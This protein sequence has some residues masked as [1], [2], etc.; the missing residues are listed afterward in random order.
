[1]LAHRVQLVGQLLQILHDRL[2][3]IHSAH[4]DQAQRE[5]VERPLKKNE[6]K[7]REYVTNTK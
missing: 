7:F 4:F 1:M 3:R 6:R 5:D 2:V